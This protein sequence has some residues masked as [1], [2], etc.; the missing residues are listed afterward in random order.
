MLNELEIERLFAE[1]AL[2]EEGR[3]LV[4]FARANSPVRKANSRLGNSIV[5]HFSKKMGSRHLELES[6][7]VESPA[8]TI[9]ENDSS[10]LEYW[11]QPFKIDLTIKDIDGNISSRMQHTPDFLV[12][13]RDGIDVHEWREES[14]LLRL[15]KEGTQFFKDDDNRW[16]YK[17]AEEFFANTGL[18]YEVHSSFEHPL[19]Y[20]Q[21]IRFL[22][23]YQKSNCSPLPEEDE[24]RLLKL[25]W[26]RGSIPFL[27]LLQEHN[28]TSD[29]IFK[30]VVKRLVFVDLYHQRL[31]ATLDLMVYRDMAIA[32]AHRI[33]N[34]DRTPVLPIPGMARLSAGTCVKYDGKEFKVMLVGGGNV[35]LKN[36]DDETISLPLDVVVALFA[37]NDIDIEG[38]ANERK[39]SD[40]SLANYSKEQ[41]E[42]ASR[43]LEAIS[44][45]DASKISIRSLQ[46][47]NAQAQGAVTQVD[48]LLSLVDRNKDK[49][50]RTARLPENSEILAKEAIGEFFNKPEGRMASA[51]YG[52]YQLLCEEHAAVPM[53]YTTFTKRVNAGTSVKEREGK[54]KAYQEASIPLILDYRFPVNGVRP[55]EVCYIDHTIMNIA[56][57]GP[58]GSELGK[59]TFT[60]ATDGNTTQTRAFYLSY[61]PPSTGVVLMVLRDYVRRHQRLPKILVVDG[62]REFRSK[63]LVWFCGLYEIELR[64]RP[65]AMPRGG[66][67]IE[68]AIGA[69]ETEV[70]AQLEGNTRIMK[71]ARMVTK[72]VNPF[73]NAVWTL[74]ALHGCLD[75]YLFK[76][77]DNLI[78]P[79]FGSTPHDYEQMRMAET[80]QREHLLVRYDENFLLLTSPHPKQCFHKIDR[81][82]G[83]WADHMYHW[84]DDLGST[85]TGERYEV[86]IEPWDSRV[87]YVNVK[88]HWVAAIA[89]NLKAYVGRTHRETEIARRAERR[90]AKTN[91][92]KDK[93]SKKHAKEMSNLWKPE[94][95]DERIG[96]QQREMAHIYSRLGM[97][98][99][100]PECLLVIK[101]SSDGQSEHTSANLNNVEPVKEPLNKDI[102][103]TE[104]SD[105][106]RDVYGYR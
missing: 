55:H 105:I 92:N 99:A 102:K 50:N 80:G 9:Y 23:D 54:R 101:E 65:S 47:W 61:D 75:E 41:I 6:R 72:S 28:L 84:H 85:K 34:A 17:A 12:I 37:S 77:K 66:S 35:L 42:V 38:T 87:V 70:L 59:P 40:K 81:V 93:M 15:E 10:C 21:N 13:R 97:T 71:N 79:A 30:A 5:M 29:S 45:G 1:L 19:T 62:G 64:H 53:S 25:I 56:T 83:V 33:I 32:K 98:V 90:L 96:K 39:S 63:E 74:T 31:D 68:R 60:L 24:G 3:Q 58:D 95:F 78:H 44:E 7:T 76:I 73:P 2:P 69:S 88:K 27:E 91:A 22:E 51:V 8:A 67:Q 57:V 16:H 18:H 26:E 4:R 36:N 52:K 46:R 86:R 49:G 89:R 103:E 82:R 48:K 11:T 43:R 14:R 20:I 94:N 100:M 106:W 104:E